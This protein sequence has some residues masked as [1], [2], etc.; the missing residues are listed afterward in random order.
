M[1]EAWVGFAIECDVDCAPV[2]QRAWAG[3]MC[4]HP[5][6]RIEVSA[7]ALGAAISRRSVW[8]LFALRYT[9]IDWGEYEMSC[10]CC[11]CF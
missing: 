6:R 4:L 3:R 7:A 2:A 9:G 5:L 11:A 8:W 10:V 1:R